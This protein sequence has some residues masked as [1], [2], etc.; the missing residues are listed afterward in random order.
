MLCEKCKQRDATVHL[1]EIIKNI[2]SEV[3]LCEICARD[4]GLNSKFSSFSLSVPDM[5][6]FLDIE[7]MEDVVDTNICLS[8]GSS[9]VDYKKNGKLGCPDC[10]HYLKKAM[11]SIVSSYHGHSRHVGKI[12][13]NYVDMR[14]TGK[15]YLESSARVMEKIET[16]TELRKKMEAA[17]KEERYEDAAVFRDR[18]R[19]IEAAES[20]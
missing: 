10:Y 6:S 12:P 20:H 15:V 1:T 7:E 3:H 5:L 4:V 2:K 18:I 17:V 9:F 13:M 19:S 11:E 16:V 14:S 8:C